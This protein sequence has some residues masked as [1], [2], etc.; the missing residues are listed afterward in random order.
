MACLSA[1]NTYEIDKLERET[2]I[3]D[4]MSAHAAVNGSSIGA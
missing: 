1:L 2:W 3:A 4:A